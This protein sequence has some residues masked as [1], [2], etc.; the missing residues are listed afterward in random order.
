M[1]NA[2]IIS[3]P[4]EA[5]SVVIGTEVSLRI[6][7]KLQSY[8]IV[9]Y[10]DVDLDKDRILYESPLA[11]MLLNRKTGDKFCAEVAGRKSRIEIISIKPLCQKS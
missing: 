6:D 7:N 9:S 10:G 5:D 3:Y 4:S 11:Q 1:N 2:K 8:S